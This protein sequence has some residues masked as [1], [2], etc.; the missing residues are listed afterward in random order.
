MAK[1]NRCL[2][3]ICIFAA[4]DFL[5]INAANRTFTLKI[6]EAAKGIE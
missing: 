3:D 1:H 4:V 6:I 2:L 5:Y